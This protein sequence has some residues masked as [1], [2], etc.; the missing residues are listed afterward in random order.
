[1]CNVYYEL[2]ISDFKHLEF[3]VTKK[4]YV[5]LNNYES[6]SFPLKK[7]Y[8]HSDELL[9][10]F[11]FFIS[12][13]STTLASVV[14]KMVFKLFPLFSYESNNGKEV[15][16]NKLDAHL[17]ALLRCLIEIVFCNVE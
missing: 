14:K 2:N 3:P 12:A 16:Q 4:S 10:K 13:S 7:T 5:S 6:R 17:D 9:K 8:L 1:M 11:S 15:A